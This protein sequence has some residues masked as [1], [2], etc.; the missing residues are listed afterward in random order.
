MTGVSFTVEIDDLV[1]HERI[2]EL[3]ARIA[4]PAAFLKSVGK[5][6]VGSARDNFARQSAP[7]G[8]PW[9]PLAPSTIRQRERKGQVPIRILQISGDL[10]GHIASQVEG[11]SV[12]IGAGVSGS[13]SWDY[14]AIHQLGGTINRPARVGTAFGRE[15]VAFPAHTITIPARPYLGVSADDEMAIIEMAE[16]WLATPKP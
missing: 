3:M 10:R 6:L 2:S 16:I 4:E 12:V 14:A 1:M 11:D 7:D 13:D 9:A 15:G 5:H 8:S